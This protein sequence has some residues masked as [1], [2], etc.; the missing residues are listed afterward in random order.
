MFLCILGACTTNW[1]KTGEYY[2]SALS[3]L[4]IQNPDDYFQTWVSGLDA[5]KP[6]F[7]FG[8]L[9]FA[10][11]KRMMY[12]SCTSERTAWK[13]VCRDPYDDAAS[14]WLALC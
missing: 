13:C 2:I 1:R 4:G 14:Q 12:M 6:G 10:T 5:L 7:G 3:G 11:L 9:G 8:T